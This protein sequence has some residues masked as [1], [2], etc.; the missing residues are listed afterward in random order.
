[1]RTMAS[2]HVAH[3]FVARETRR[4][5]KHAK[6]KRCMVDN[7]NARGGSVRRVGV[8]LREMLKAHRRGPGRRSQPESARTVGA[9]LREML[10]ARGGGA[11]RKCNSKRKPAKGVGAQL[12]EMLKARGGGAPRKCNS[13]RKPAKGSAPSYARC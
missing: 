12:R 1:M 10:K 8:Q 3:Q 7:S 2:S 5:P 9:Q 6:V 11:P 13:K 4:Q